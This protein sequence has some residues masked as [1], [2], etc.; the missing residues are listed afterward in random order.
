MLASAV[1]DKLARVEDLATNPSIGSRAMAI[2][3]LHQV[4]NELGIELFPIIKGVNDDTELSIDIEVRGVGHER[5]V[6][7]RH[8]AVI[9]R[10]D[11]L[12]CFLAYLKLCSD[13]ANPS[14]IRRQHL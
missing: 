1:D 2:F 7:D 12:G 14:P 9:D 3:L 6:L 10:S 8:S 4:V 13:V 11:L 5:D